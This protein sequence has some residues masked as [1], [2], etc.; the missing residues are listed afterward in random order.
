MAGKPR[1]AIRAAAIASLA[2]AYCCG[3]L[4]ARGRVASALESSFPG[5]ALERRDG[6]AGRFVAR[7][8]GEQGQL[9]FLQVVNGQGWGGPLSVAVLVSEGCRIEAVSILEHKETPSFVDFLESRGFF[10][11]Y[12]GKSV[13]DPFV[14]GEDVDAVTTATISS[15]G[16][17]KSICRAA[18]QIG[19]EQYSLQIL[20]PPGEW[21]VGTD[22]LALVALYAVVLASVLGKYRKVRYVTMA[23]GLAFLG[24]MVARPISIANLAGLLLGFFPDVQEQPF[25]WLL[26]GGVLL[27][28]VLLARNVYCFWMCPF[29]SLQEFMTLITEVKVRASGR[30]ADALRQG[31]Y[32][33]LWLSLMIAFITNNP[34]LGAFEP[35]AVLF[36][37]NGLDVQWYLLSV[38][39]VGAFL[40]PRFW[41]RFLCPV[42]GA[43][44][45]L[46]RTKRAVRERV[47][48]LV[49]RPSRR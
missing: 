1:R 38:A 17:N 19:R 39:L 35:F 2:V 23:L 8:R 26:I 48:A 13:A 47:V 20:E 21:R 14:L 29:G 49:T 27:M 33:L 15:A 10:E 28:T 24:F 7:T 30:T 41:C 46:A 22:E 42:G 6:A 16:F 45:L 40:V 18:Y 44:G 12:D 11:Q 31:V 37:L 5:L 36:S 3:I 4:L 34:A 43:L 9:G 32:V 25:W